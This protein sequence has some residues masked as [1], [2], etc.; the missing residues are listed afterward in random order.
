MNKLE[1]LPFLVERE[2]VYFGF[3]KCWIKMININENVKV[4]WLM[5]S[6]EHN[7]GQPL[8]QRMLRFITDPNFLV[9]SRTN[10]F[11]TMSFLRHVYVDVY[12]MLTTRW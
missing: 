9:D 1:W 11:L 7:Q 5:I 4:S 10:E 6:V 3:F 8:I 12:Q 2:G